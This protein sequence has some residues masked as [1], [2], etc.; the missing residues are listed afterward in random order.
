MTQ[1]IHVEWPTCAVDGCIGISLTPGQP[2]LAHGSEEET[3]AALK[4]IGETGVID[5]RGVSITE[6][7]LE[8]V[9][10]A[11]PRGEDGKPSLQGSRFD[12]A[13]FSGDAEFD[14][15]T[16]SGDAVFDGATF[17]GS[18]EFG[19]ATFTGNAQ[20]FQ[21]AFVGGARFDGATFTG[22]AYFGGATFTSAARFD[23]ATFP[24]RKEATSF[25]G[26]RVLAPGADHIWPKG[27]CT[28]E[29][30]DG[31]HTIV[32]VDSSTRS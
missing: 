2:C 25:E 28:G 16:F 1:R 10:A 11:A 9:L 6:D 31:E 22:A 18:A 8:R 4:L 15:V 3:A 23:R 26:S 29:T 21:A 20:F 30:G 19:D 14:E 12:W 17:E 7:L 32:R 5:A 13:T 24:S 27:W